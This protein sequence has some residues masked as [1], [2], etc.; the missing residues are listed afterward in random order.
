[1]MFKLFTDVHDFYRESFDLLMRHEAQ[2]SL[3]LGNLIIGHEGTDKSEWRDPA[4]WLMATVENENGVQLV[5]LR[6]PPHHLTMY[7]KDNRIDD[8]VLECLVK[9]LAGHEITGVTTEKELASRFAK[10]YCDVNGLAYET[11]F[12]QRVYELSRVNP[13]PRVGTLRRV[14]KRD[15]SFLPFWV[16]GFHFH[17]GVDKS[18]EM[19]K[20][21]QDWD[22]YHNRILHRKLY[23]LEVEGIPVSMAGIPRATPTICAVGPVYTPPYFRGKGYATSCVAKLSQLLL[24]QGFAKCALYTD[25]ANPTS[26]SI[27]QKIGYTAI[28]DSIMLNFVEK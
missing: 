10:A 2:N 27:Y 14:E 28:C 5:A 21:P 9:G 20:V 6:T 4:K 15:M 17:V 16:E 25:L 18:A 26:N 11:E 1:M 13:V 24:D 19:M 8:E 12:N 7:A 22:V 3:V 23:I